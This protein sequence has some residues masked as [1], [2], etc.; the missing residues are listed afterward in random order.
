MK[1]SKNILF[2]H[3]AITF[4]VLIAVV[5]LL[6]VVC[7]VFGIINLSHDGSVLVIAFFGILATFIV[8]TNYAQVVNIKN[9][10]DC[11]IRDLKDQMEHLEK[12]FGTQIEKVKSYNVQNMLAVRNQLVDFINS[13]QNKNAYEIGKILVEKLRES[14]DATTEI[15]VRIK[16]GRKND[17]V[18]IKIGFI[19]GLLIFDYVNVTQIEGYEFTAKDY[20]D[21][22]EIV[23]FLYQ[24]KSSKR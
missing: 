19:R 13:T 8:V 16:K 4:F 22:N 21:L 6:R 10:T 15:N 24:L 1:I 5:V 20:R 23:S 7:K 14:N 17:A 9:N 11:E 2:R 18:T 12:S 3:L